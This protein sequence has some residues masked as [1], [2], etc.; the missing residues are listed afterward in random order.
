[1]DIF[2]NSKSSDR[3]ANFKNINEKINQIISGFNTFTKM[4]NNKIIEINS[5]IATNYNE[6][7]QKTQIH[8]IGKLKGKPNTEQ[9]F[10]FVHGSSYFIFPYKARILGI[11]SE[12]DIS[13]VEIFLSNE[14]VNQFPIQVD[15][16]D[17]I[18]FKP[19]RLAAMEENTI[20][21]LSLQV[22]I[23]RS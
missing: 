6:L 4:Y 15:K 20:I 23:Y 17:K 12:P 9:V 2:C 11:H 5:K 18:S 1:M 10:K 8:L 21:S 7:N 16:G 13:H 19:Q 22:Y 14:K 3:E